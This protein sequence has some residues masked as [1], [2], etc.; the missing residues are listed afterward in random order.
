MSISHEPGV[1]GVIKARKPR[2]IQIMPID[3]FIIFFI[4]LTKET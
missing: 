2:I 1:N 3:F 4:R